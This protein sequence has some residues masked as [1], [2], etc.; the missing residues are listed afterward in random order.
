MNMLRLNFT[1]RP[2]D[3]RGAVAGLMAF[4][5]PVILILAGLTLNVAYMELCRTD[6]RIASD[7]SARAASCTLAATSDRKA[8]LR[9]AHEVAAQN[10][11]AGQPL[12]FAKND[13]Q[14]GQA[15]RSNLASRYVFQPNDEA[16]NAVR[17]TARRAA[18][19]PQGAIDLLFPSP[20][21]GRKFEPIQSATA[22]QSE[23]DI[24]IVI[25]VSRSM[26]Y[27]AKELAEIAPRPANALPHWEFSDPYPSGSRW[28]DV[29]YAIE[30]LLG[31]MEKSP[32]REQLALITYSDHAETVLPLTSA[33]TEWPRTM[34]RLSHK[35]S[36]SLNNV[37]AGIRQAADELLHHGDQRPWA[38][39]VLIVVTDGTFVQG[40]DPAKAVWEATSQGIM[41]FPITYTAEA[42]PQLLEEVAGAGGGQLFHADNKEALA[43]AFANVAKSLPTLLIE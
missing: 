5:I 39:K 15:G 8:A 35:S 14:F 6:L 34:A 26:A 38:T 24:A 29:A 18:D 42:T 32:L 37:A 16:A 27:T 20:L 28:H 22:A 41:V 9:A 23:A 1:R 25:S 7:A 17:V 3:R 36:R 13:V 11:V 19:S 30:V 33:L 43:R 31:H 2:R 12:V 40:D 21:S 4:L 10:Q